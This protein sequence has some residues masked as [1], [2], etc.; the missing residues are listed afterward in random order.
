LK[1]ATF[2]PVLLYPHQKAMSLLNILK[3]ILSLYM[4]WRHVGK[5]T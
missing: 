4:Q 5:W 1:L 3:V 2:S